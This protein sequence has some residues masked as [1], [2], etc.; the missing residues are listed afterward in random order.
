MKRNRP[1]RRIKQ[2]PEMLRLVQLATSLSE[3]SSQIEDDFWEKQL[4]ALVV[5]L[6]ASGAEETLMAAL[7]PLYRETS[8]AYGA[9]VSRIEACAETRYAE[10]PDGLD[11]LMIAIPILSWSR[12]PI[13]AGAIPPAQL[14]T[15]RA[16]LQANVLASGTKLSLCD[17]L[18]SPDQIPQTYIDTAQL[19]DKVAQAAKHD[20]DVKI[21]PKK[22]AET[23]SFLSDSRYLIGAI[24]APQGAAMF[25]WQEEGG[26]HAESTRKWILQGSD[27]IRP[28]LPACALELQPV[29]AY[30][31]AVLDADRASRPWSLRSAVA[32]L[33]TVLNIL[34]SDLVAVIARFHE[35]QTEEYRIGLALRQDQT[36]VH[37]VVWPLLENE[38]NTSELSAEIET[39][40]QEAGIT[41]VIQLSQRFPIEYCDDCGTPLYPSPEGEPTHAELPEEQAENTQRHLH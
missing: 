27:L 16:H 2:T 7:D 1:P 40:L 39:V 3:S 25:R 20:R 38:D 29:G 36:V 34:P 12:F 8:P 4:T 37:G 21:D 33:Q 28:L 19:M 26:N 9:L 41:E 30:H 22:M 6:I 18:Y 14:D 17:R 32:F 35:D 24:A 11:A 23:M 5:H 15:I 31:A 10:T 13:P